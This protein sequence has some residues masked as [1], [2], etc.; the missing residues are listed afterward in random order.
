M[1][2]HPP[3]TVVIVTCN[4]KDKLLRLLSSVLASDY[5]SGQLEILVIDNVS[6]DRTA[7]GVAENFPEVRLLRQKKNLYSA[8]GRNVGA[9]T[10]RGEYVFFIDDDNILESDCISR[11]V[12]TMGADETLGVAAPLMM[13]YPEQD[14]IWCAGGKL[15]QFGMPSHLHEGQNRSAIELPSLIRDVDYYPNSYMVRRTIFGQ[16]LL[17]DTENFPH[18]WNEQDFCR[19][20]RLAGYNLATVTDAVTYHDVGYSTRITRIGLSRTFDQAQSRVLFRRLYLNSPAQWLFFFFVLLPVSTVY[21]MKMFLAQ[22]EV[23]FW[24]LLSV[25]CRGT[26]SGITKKL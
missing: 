2:N 3:V 16:G 20:V 18:N 1:T 8:R 9:M 26:C 10:A 17:H 21:Y 13:L 11:L 4:R 23:G 19:R 22:K 15:S 5:P 24:A 6:A 12:A 25:Y 7:E 14:A